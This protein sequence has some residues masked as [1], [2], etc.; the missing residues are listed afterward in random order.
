MGTM[1][2][3][4]AITTPPLALLVLILTPSYSAAMQASFMIAYD[5]FFAP[6]PSGDVV[7]ICI[8]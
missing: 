5:S 1:I 6:I 3:N 7:S 8:F 4:M 2:S